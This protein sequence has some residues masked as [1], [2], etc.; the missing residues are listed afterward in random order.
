[1]RLPE[2]GREDLSV[3]GQQIYDEI[4]ASRGAVRGP[5]AALMHSPEIAG[6]TAHLGAYLRFDTSLDPT[7]LQIVTLAVAREWDCQYEWTAH[8]PQAREALVR[9]DVITAIKERRAPEG[10]TEDEA[11][12]VRYVHELLRSHSISSET[13]DRIQ[14]RFSPLEL[15]DLTTT[16]GYYS[17]LACALIA[18]EVQ[19]AEGVVP[20][21]PI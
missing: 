9:E 3:R 19:P 17:M 1:M 6:R 12:L 7:T 5:F 11:L 8:E 14:S 13:F 2:V 20:L 21:L 10:L 18:Y 15:T 16:I 4:F